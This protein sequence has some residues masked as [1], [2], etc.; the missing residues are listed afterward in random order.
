ML[1]VMRQ[2]VAARFLARLDDDY[3]PRMRRL[4]VAESKQRGQ[5]P[6]HRVAVIGAPPAIEAA[7]ELVADDPRRPR[8]VSVFPADHLRLLIEMTVEQHRIAIIPAAA[9]GHL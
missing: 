7:V 1:N 2:I 9:G 5:R 8:T 4:L 3:A 6:E